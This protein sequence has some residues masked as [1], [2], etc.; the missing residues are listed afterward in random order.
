MSLKPVNRVSSRHIVL[1][2]EDEQKCPLPFRLRDMRE[3]LHDRKNAQG[4]IF[5]GKVR[6]VSVG[7]QQY[8]FIT[9]LPILFTR[10]DAGKA[11]NLPSGN[12]QRY[13]ARATLPII[14]DPSLAEREFF[15]V[16]L[17]PS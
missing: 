5:L 6:T 13:N 7:N 17:L 16:K 1:R 15:C 2:I 12:R 10:Q 14:S 9:F 8:S 11:E 3:V 4:T